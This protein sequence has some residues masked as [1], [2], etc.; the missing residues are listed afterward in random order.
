MERKNTVCCPACGSAAVRDLLRIPQVPVYCN[1]LWPDREQAL[2]AASGDL[3]LGFCT[4]CTHLF[5]TAF[6][7]KLTEYTA[8][9]DNSLHY[10]PRFSQYAEQLAG[11]L[12]HRHGLK[13]KRIVEIGCGKGDFLRLLCAQGDN[14]GFGFD[15][16]FEPERVAATTDE[17]VS[18]FQDFYDA[19]FAKRCAP[20]FLCCRH[21][22]EHIEQPRRFLQ[23]LRSTL[24][25]RGDVSFYCEV[26]NGLFTLKDMGI[27]DLIYEHCGYFS[28]N[29]LIR[30]FSDSG[31]DVSAADESFGGQFI[32]VE[33][34]PANGRDKPTALVTEAVDEVRRYADSFAAKYRATVDEWLGRLAESSREGRRTVVWGAGSKGVT[35]LNVAAGRSG[36]EFVVDVNPHKQ[37]RFVAGTG[38]QVLAPASL[39]SIGATD[40]I[41]MNP[42]YLDEVSSTIRSMGLD[43][44]VVCVQ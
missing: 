42:M 24:D 21:V 7:P 8:A 1:V 44:G 11:G 30:A 36:V 26:P 19:E 22:L 39:R 13:G 20:D 16:S 10:S 28:L 15:R 6:D 9:Y 27:W 41:V 2:E 29:S 18:F 12:I 17:R 14:Q 5:N 37:G 3:A 40:V 33:A 25:A 43:L 38:Q 34:R 35:F 32:W 23:M 31:F 4:D